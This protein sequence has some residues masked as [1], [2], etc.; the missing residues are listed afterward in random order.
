MRK[1]SVILIIFLIICPYL[2]TH[3]YKSEVTESI[4]YDSNGNIISKTVY[5]QYYVLFNDEWTLSSLQ[6]IVYDAN[7][8]LVF[9]S[10]PE[11]GAAAWTTNHYN[12][13]TKNK[14]LNTTIFRAVDVC[15]YITESFYNKDRIY[16][17]IEKVSSSPFIITIGMSICS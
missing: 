5:T 17:K 3:E 11:L 10:L 15:V 16:C 12:Y 9:E 7:G 14:L 1:L 2:F 6:T 13:D 4:D 8:N